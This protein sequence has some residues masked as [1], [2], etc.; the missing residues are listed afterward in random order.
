MGI[1][2]VDTDIMIDLAADASDAKRSLQILEKTTTLAVSVITEMELFIGCRNKTELRN[3]ER[4]L[5]RFQV[6]PL[7]QKISDTASQLIRKYRLSH[8]LLI[9]DALIASTS[10]ILDCDLATRNRKDYRFIEGIR[11]LDY[12]L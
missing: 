4:F 7:N 3:T 1:I 10:I 9:P 2:L 12:P 6:I 8:G 11:L 5:G